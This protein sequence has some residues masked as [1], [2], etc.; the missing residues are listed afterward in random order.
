[1]ETLDAI[2]YLDERSQVI[3]HLKNE[4]EEQLW[5]AE[6]LPKD[7]RVLELGA[8]YGTVSCLVSAIVDEP[9]KHVAVEPDVFVL[10]ALIYN[11][12]THSG[13]F[14]IVVGAISRHP[15]C[16][17]YTCG[18][19]NHLT[20]GQPNIQT[21]TVEE[22]EKMYDVSFNCLI[23]DCEGALEMF[24]RQNPELLTRLDTVI[25]EADCPQ[26]CDYDYVKRVLELNGLKHVVVGFQNVYKRLPDRADPSPG[27]DVE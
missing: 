15:V 19:G 26:R 18:Y 1:M 24:C 4:R 23:A 20:Q 8:R 5:V 9:T 2:P 11:K 16:L 10:P 12:L 17:D 25:F 21:F 7:A 6:H 14:H 3:P 13:K 27:C 22:I